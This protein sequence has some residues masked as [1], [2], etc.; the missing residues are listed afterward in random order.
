MAQGCSLKVPLEG[1][2]LIIDIVFQNKLGSNE[3]N[4]IGRKF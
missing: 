4:E 2:I 1:K 3:T